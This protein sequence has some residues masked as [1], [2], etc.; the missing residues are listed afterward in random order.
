MVLG[1]LSSM[2]ELIIYLSRYFT[3]KPQENRHILQDFPG[4]FILFTMYPN[5]WRCRQSAAR[6]PGRTA[7]KDLSRS[8]VLI[9]SGLLCG[10]MP[11]RCVS[12]PTIGVTRVFAWTLSL[13][14]PPRVSA[15]E[16]D[17]REEF[18]KSRW[19]MIEGANPRAR[20][21]V[22]SGQGV[23]TDIIYNWAGVGDLL[24]MVWLL[25][26]LWGYSWISR[27]GQ[28]GHPDRRACII[29]I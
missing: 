1:R 21:S 6:A 26:E 10:H 20:V 7:R 8:V 9:I 2:D 17:N 25:R 11:C 15:L 29:N 18:K 27:L 13:I 28:R 3:N 14:L 19:S 4:H 16:G 23:L 5:R 22:R 24:M 12:D